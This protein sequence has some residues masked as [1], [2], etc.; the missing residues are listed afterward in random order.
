M[1]KQLWITLFLAAFSFLACNHRDNK[2]IIQGHLDNNTYE[3][4]YL[5]KTTSDGTFLIDSTEIRK[6]KFS[7]K[8]KSNDLTIFPV[9]YQ[10][11]LSPIN[12]MSIIAKPGDRL[13]I[14]AN[15][16]NIVKSYTIEGSDDAKLMLQLDRMLTAFIDT[17][18]MLYAFYEQ[19]IENDDMR[20][21]VE[22][23]YNTLLS[24]YNADLICF[25]KQNSSSMVTISAFYQTYNRRRFL[26]E[27]ENLALLQL[28]HHDLKRQ[29]P[30]CENVKFLEQRIRKI[31]R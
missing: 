31:E 28:I 10:L 11:S 19:H 16:E 23:Q 4:I 26:D 9:F 8:L 29:Y 3:K 21:H 13:Q 27:Q 24:Q 22:I 30:D 6:G 14:A 25:I 18:E 2:I 17:V 5:S 20:E 1:T 15:A 12:G 7:F